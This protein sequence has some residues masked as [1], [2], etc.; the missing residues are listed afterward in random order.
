MKT[1]RILLEE[2]YNIS[3]PQYNMYKYLSYVF[4]FN[5]FKPRKHYFLLVDTHPLVDFIAMEVD[6][7]DKCVRGD[8]AYWNFV[9]EINE[10]SQEIMEKTMSGEYD[11]Y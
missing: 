2:K 11:P 1:L 10:F 5:R 7:K 3:I 6:Y 8:K 4:D 9:V